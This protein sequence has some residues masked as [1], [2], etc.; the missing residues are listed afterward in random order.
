MQINPLL[1]SSRAYFLQ[2]PTCTRI[3]K[4]QLHSIMISYQTYVFLIMLARERVFQ[5]SVQLRPFISFAN[6]QQ[7]LTFSHH[8]MI[9]LKYICFWQKSETL[10]SSVCNGIQ[11]NFLYRHAHQKHT[12]LEDKL[13]KP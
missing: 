12:Q 10:Y 13:S 11:T 8:R 5:R 7:F 6:C 4:I 3:Q 9:S 2:S 1:F